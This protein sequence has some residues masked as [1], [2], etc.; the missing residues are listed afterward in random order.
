MGVIEEIEIRVAEILEDVMAT[1]IDDNGEWLVTFNEARDELVRMILVS[2]NP[3]PVEP[4]VVPE[5]VPEIPAVTPSG[6]KSVSE[7][8]KFS[9]DKEGFIAP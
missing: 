8:T 5:T 2:I 1:D 9:E 3:A 7:W 4:A 6:V